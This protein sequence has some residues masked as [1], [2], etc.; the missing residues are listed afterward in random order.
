MKKFFLIALIA[1]PTFLHAQTGSKVYDLL[2][3]TYTT[4]K[5]QG[6]YVYHFDTG[7]GKITY[8]NKVTG[9]DNPSYIAIARG[10]HFV[11]SVNEVGTD[12]KGSVSAFAFDAASGGLK[13]INK[14]PS[15]GAGPCYILLDK[16]RKNAFVANYAGGS[17]TVLPINA[18][19]SLAAP[20]QNIQDQ[21]HSIDKTRQ[22]EP[23][24]HTAILSPDE[25]YLMYTDLGT[26]KINICKYDPSAAKPL[27]PA[28][29]AFAAVTP[30]GGPR[31]LAFHPNGKFLYLIQEMGARI[32][33]YDYHKGQLK[34]I[35]TASLVP[36]G[37]KG[38]VGAADI[39]ISADGKFLY[40]TNRGDANELEVFAIDKSTGALTFVQRTSTLGKTP[41]NFTLDPTGNFLLVANQNSDDVY[42]FRIDKETG[43]LTYT[44]E[45]LE[46]G[47]PSCLKFCP[48]E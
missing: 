46:V 15:I 9:V 34:E 39:H 32:A 26:D 41:R 28:N 4:G 11:Y 3:G 23:H 43:K 25:K 20:S 8:L 19:G 42:V 6:I 35:S 14:Q 33:V 21:D 31:H 10:N 16:A 5:S 12:R 44:G 2:V 37:F 36:D 27:T 40:S 17:F 38:T 22:N 13:L 7:T 18:D 48:A 24:V 47:N 45:K 1:L 29:P 30:G